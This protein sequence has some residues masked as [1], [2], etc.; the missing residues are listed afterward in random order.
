MIA[1]D[2]PTDID[3]ETQAARVVFVVNFLLMAFAEVA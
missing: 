2:L 3:D 1:C